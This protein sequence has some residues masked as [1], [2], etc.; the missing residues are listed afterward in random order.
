[1]SIEEKILCICKD[2]IGSNWCSAEY[3]AYKIGLPINACNK[4]LNGPEFSK[5]CGLLITSEQTKLFSN[6][7]LTKKA[8]HNANL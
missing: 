7:L 6:T 2:I 5:D 8:E 4:F 3:L 1:M